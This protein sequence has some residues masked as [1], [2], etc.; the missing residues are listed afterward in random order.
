MLRIAEREWIIHHYFRRDRAQPRDR[1]MRLVEQPRMG[2]AG[3]KKTIAGL[4]NRLVLD[5][6]P[7]PWD[8]LFEPSAEEQRGAS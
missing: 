2:I 7:Q 8:R 3:G 6:N 5:S 1:C 4:E